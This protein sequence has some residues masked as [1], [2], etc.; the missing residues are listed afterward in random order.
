MR[1][2]H[3]GFEC[4]YLA[5]AMATTPIWRGGFYVRIQ[6]FFYSG[7]RVGP[8]HWEWYGGDLRGALHRVRCGPPS[9]WAY[10]AFG[11]LRRWRKCIMELVWV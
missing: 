7:P 1:V 5:S 4:V 2:N 9:A 11:N 6:W 10:D 8:T 3:F